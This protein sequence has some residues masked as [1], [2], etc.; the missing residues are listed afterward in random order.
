MH[1]SSGAPGGTLHA[2]EHLEESPALT[3]IAFGWARPFAFE[4]H[5]VDEGVVSRW[6]FRDRVESPAD[7]I[8]VLPRCLLEHGGERRF[9]T[10]DQK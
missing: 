7:E 3:L 10:T 9:E 5:V 1:S 8:A 2:L 4:V 6:G